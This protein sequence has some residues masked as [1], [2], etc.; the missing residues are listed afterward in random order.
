MPVAT[1][2]VEEMRGRA[3]AARRRASEIEA[4]IANGEEVSDEDLDA[5]DAATDE[6]S[7]LY[8][9]VRA[10]ESVGRF[11]AVEDDA[12]RPSGRRGSRI[13]FDGLPP[14]D[15]GARP[16]RPMDRSIVN[17]FDGRDAEGLAGPHT[18]PRNTRNGLHRYSVLRAYQGAVSLRDGG[19]FDGL[20]AEVHQHLRSQRR[21]ITRGILIPWDAP[22]SRDLLP[23][24]VRRRDLTT[25]TGSGAVEKL[26]YTPM[27]ELLRA[28][29]VLVALG[30]RLMTGMTSSFAIPRQAT[31]TT[32]SWVTEGNAGTTTSA[33]IDQVEFVPRTATANTKLTR[34]FIEQS[35]VD[36]EDF[37]VDDLTSTV[38]QALEKAAINGSGVG[39]EPLGLLQN[40]DVPTISSLGTNGGALTW[41]K[42]LEFIGKHGQANAPL[43][44]R[45]F[46]INPQTKAKLGGTPR[47]TGYPKYLYDFDDRDSPIAGFSYAES[48]NVPSTLAKGTSGNVLSAVLFGSWRELIIALFSGVD[49]VVD[50]YT[51]STAGNVRISV[52]QDADVDVRHPQS[53]VKSVEV[54]TA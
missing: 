41:L 31:G 10:S 16:A 12:G 37:A 39:A 48:T 4:R 50:P 51:E 9:S 22:V 52:F 36:A 23:E 29:L 26:V 1:I 8:R 2:N 6:A 15:D 25:T 45:A 53:F 40:T 20:E 21:S 47:E 43:E 13:G 38:A 30:A 32:A 28:K 35:V 18:D 44:N 7:R 27:I 24:G 33:T 54:S 19:A 42:L 3:D 49:I 14:F 11:R 34:K 17:R 46:L 5:M